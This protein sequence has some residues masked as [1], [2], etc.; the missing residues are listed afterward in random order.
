MV[1]TLDRFNT[2]SNELFS[3]VDIYVGAT[4]VFFHYPLQDHQVTEFLETLCTYLQTLQ[5]LYLK[6]T[7]EDYF[8]LVKIHFS[9]NFLI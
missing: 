4:L 9:H 8:V 2:L 1:Y 7:T 6:L 5:E 3:T